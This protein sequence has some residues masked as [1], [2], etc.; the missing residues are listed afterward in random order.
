MR[1]GEEDQEKEGVKPCGGKIQ[2]FKR[3]GIY[4]EPMQID[5]GSGGAD[6][7]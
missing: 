1:M 7:D 4:A 5:D 6:N 3:N 2:L